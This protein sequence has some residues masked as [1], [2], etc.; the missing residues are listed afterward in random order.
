MLIFEF[1]CTQLLYRPD[2]DSDGVPIPYNTTDL[3][4]KKRCDVHFHIGVAS[5][6]NT[7]E[8]HLSLEKKSSQVS[9]IADRHPDENDL[10]YQV[11]NFVHYI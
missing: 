6:F 5:M 3:K 8:A 9:S 2:C 10:E 4:T 1:N 11:I 7:K